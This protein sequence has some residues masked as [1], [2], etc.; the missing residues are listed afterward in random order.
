MRLMKKQWTA[1]EL[2]D[3]IIGETSQSVSKCSVCGIKNIF[4]EE[5]LVISKIKKFKILDQN[6]G[7]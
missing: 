5:S 4:P 3:W 1:K 6:L 7:W 2:V